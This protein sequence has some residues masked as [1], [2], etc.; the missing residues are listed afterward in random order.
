MKMN[1]RSLAQAFIV[2][3]L[4]YE[5][6]Q[7]LL[8]TGSV[9]E[10]LYALK[11]WP[12]LALFVS[13]LL[14]FAA[15]SFGAYW[16]FHKTYG[17]A[18]RYLPFALLI[19]VA[20]VAILLRYGM[21]EVLGPILFNWRNY[22][23][24][25]TLQYYIFDNLYY[26]VVYLSVGTVFFFVQY[27]QY[28]EGRQRELEL[29]NQQ[30]ELAFLR[31]QL[32]PHFL[33]NILNNIYT[34]VYYKSDNALRSVEKLSALLRYALYE[35]AEKVLVKKEMEHV[36][37]LIELQR[38][39][40]DYELALEMQIATDVLHLKIAP[41]LLVPLVENAIKHGNL[42]DPAKPVLMRLRQTGDNLVWDISNEKQLRQ[43]DEVGGIGLPN[44]RKRLQLLYGDRAR[45]SVSET[46]QH[47]TVQLKIELAAC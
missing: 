20:L 21:Q 16:M 39:R 15:Y 45:L 5:P 24:D 33:F 46:D 13:N 6:L 25:T 36:Y 38:M 7:V 9:T 47:F 37:D 11:G 18:S 31:S 30:T 32:N 40:L 12:E 3:Y 34:L 14:Y 10:A 17:S 1:I 44:I 43:K 23:A 28:R 42:R 2:F 41:L 8:D 27:A 22:A 26:A 35:K 29:Q 19:P 4:V